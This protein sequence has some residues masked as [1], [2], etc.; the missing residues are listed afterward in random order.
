MDKFYYCVN[1]FRNGEPVQLEGFVFAD[2]ERN[3]VQELIDEEIIDPYG[4]EFL[5]LEV[6]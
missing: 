6:C 1:T 3:V 4:Y 5:E 2:S